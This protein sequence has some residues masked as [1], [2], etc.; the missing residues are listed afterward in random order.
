MRKNPNFRT[1]SFI[2]SALLMAC[3]IF[4]SDVIC[5]N[6]FGSAISLFLIITFCFAV[7][8]IYSKFEKW[9]LENGISFKLFEKKEPKEKKQ[10]EEDFLVPDVTI[11]DI[12]AMAEKASVSENCSDDID[13]NAEL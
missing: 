11:D 1:L 6:I 13:K 3:L 12:I 8:Y 9:N 7:G 5:K 4:V 2:M 10:E